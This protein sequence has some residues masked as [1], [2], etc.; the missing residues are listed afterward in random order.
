VSFD[1]AN[2]NES[3]DADIGTSSIF[4]R[5]TRSLYSSSLCKSTQVFQS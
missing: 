1:V 3:D 5:D 2:A 4:R